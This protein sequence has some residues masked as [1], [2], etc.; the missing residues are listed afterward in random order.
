MK[1]LV[2]K[3]SKKNALLLLRGLRPFSQCYYEYKN[4]TDYDDYDLTKYIDNREQES[5][6]SQLANLTRLLAH[7][8][9]LDEEAGY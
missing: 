7:K 1:T 4:G 9:G 3:I 6:A 5:E 8:I 2:N